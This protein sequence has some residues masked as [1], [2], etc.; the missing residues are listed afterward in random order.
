MTSPPI[1]PED[2]YSKLLGGLKER[3]RSAR[4]RA[5]LAIN[6]E[7]ILLYWTIGR[8]ILAR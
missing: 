3:I 6:E 8:D 4:M 7:L 2:E 1:Q 5:A